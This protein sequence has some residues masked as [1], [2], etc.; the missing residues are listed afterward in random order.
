MCRA[1]TPIL[2]TLL[3]KGFQTVSVLLL[4]CLI[5]VGCSGYGLKA[6]P[7]PAL[8]AKATLRRAD[9]AFEAGEVLRAGAAVRRTDD[10]SGQQLA[11]YE[12]A[13]SLYLRVIES[14]PKSSIAK[15]AHYQ[16]A[17]IY[18]RFY[19]W[20]LAMEHYQ[21]ILDVAPTGDYVYEAENGM[22]RI[23]TARAVILR[24]HIQSLNAGEQKGTKTAAAALYAIAGAYKDLQ[25][26]SQAIGYYEAV[27]KAF[28]E[29]PEAP[30]AA[31]ELGRV[32]SYKLYN[33]PA[34]TSVFLDVIEKFPDTEA[35]AEARTHLAQIRENLREIK[36]LT[37]ENVKHFRD[38]KEWE[39]TRRRQRSIF[40]RDHFVSRDQ[41]ISNIYRIAAAWEK[42]HNDPLAIDTY[43]TL[44]REYPSVKFSVRYVE[45][46]IGVLYQQQGAY[47]HAIEVYDRL[48]ENPL[49]SRFED[50]AE[51]QRAV[52]YHTLG[53]KKAAYEGFKAYIHMRKGE[54]SYLRQAEVFLRQYEQDTD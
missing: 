35:A 49:Q 21:N 43:K 5:F 18:E 38:R 29:H 52:C 30:Q 37:A 50:E 41:F 44:I 33:Y 31:F 53:E 39:K 28:P 48:L 42:L 2:K 36:K 25:D 47:R 27:V 9:T 6:I 7:I 54:R 13:K 26:Y 46:R 1:M 51:Y 10:H 34:G 24:K 23:R 4:C 17:K 40:S 14:D 19:A 8:G 20:D 32:Y 15:R 22:A 12:K 16:V 3:K 11:S 45:F